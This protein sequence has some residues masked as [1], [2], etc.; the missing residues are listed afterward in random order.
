MVAKLAPQL[1]VLDSQVRNLRL[2]G[3]E[4]RMPAQELALHVRRLQ[5]ETLI[6]EVGT[7]AELV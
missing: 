1:R 2:Q 7:T 5:S 4:L 6:G 3:A